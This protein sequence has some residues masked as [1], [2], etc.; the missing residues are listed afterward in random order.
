MKSWHHFVPNHGPKL[1]Y[2]S[3]GARMSTWS[4]F[5]FYKT[6]KC[7]GHHL[8]Y[9]E[10]LSPHRRT[11]KWVNKPGLLVSKG[12]EKDKQ[13]LPRLGSALQSWTYIFHPT[14]STKFLLKNSKLVSTER[15]QH[16][17]DQSVVG[18]EIGQ[19]GQKS[20][21][22]AKDQVYKGPVSGWPV[23]QRKECSVIEM[24]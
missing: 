1:K 21:I 11:V 9:P 12:Q 6:G 15:R 18:W 5:C 14:F 20:L 2:I 16:R 17:N 23:T 19:R 8:K 4:W 7:L 24:C 13:G 22:Q 3:F 10:A